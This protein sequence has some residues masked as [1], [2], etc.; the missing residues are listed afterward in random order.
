MALTPKQETF[1][2]EYLIDLNA[3]QA[4]IRAGY[5]ARTAR[6]IGQENLTKPDIQ[7]AIQEAMDARSKRTEITADRVLEEYAKIGFAD[8]KDY[9]SFRTEKT[10]VGYHEGQP[11]IDYADVI[12]MK[13]SEE[14]DGAAVAEIRHTKEGIAFK[15]HDKKGALDSIARHLGMFNKD[16]LT[17]NG[18]MSHEHRH[19]LK[20]LSKEEL[21]NLEYIITKAADTD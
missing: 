1:V 16:A 10:V 14:I 4:A 20:K 12:E 6:K 21:A 18:T 8:I 7:K 17:V 13:P 19:D 9:L 2:A 15:L 5:S 11:M 3:T